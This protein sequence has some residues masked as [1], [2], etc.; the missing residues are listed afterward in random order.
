M[1]TITAEE[2]KQLSLKQKPKKRAIKSPIK[3]AREYG[4]EPLEV[5][6]KVKPLSVNAAWQGQRFKTDEYKVYERAVFYSL[7]SLKI[8]KPP[9]SIYFEFGLSNVM[10][11]WDNPVKT[12]QDILQKRY[13]FNDK[14]ILEARV[15]KVK[16]KKGEEYFKVRLSSFRQEGVLIE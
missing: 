11:D 1:E 13:E 8:P 16:V 7:P 2:Y 14:D 6:Q 9:Y 12:T 5:K 15:K 10:S 3:E 4:V